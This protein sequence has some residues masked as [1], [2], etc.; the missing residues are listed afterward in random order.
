[1][2][3]VTVLDQLEI[4]LL[5]EEQ[6]WDEEVDG[7]LF[8]LSDAEFEGEVEYDPYKHRKARGAHYPSGWV[9]G[10]GAV[11][12]LVEAARLLVEATELRGHLNEQLTHVH[13]TALRAKRC[14]VVAPSSE[15]NLRAVE[16]TW[17]KGVASFNASKVLVEAGFPVDTGYRKRYKVHL[18]Q[19]SKKGPVLIIDMRQPV[20][21]K[22]L[23]KRKRKAR[24]GAQ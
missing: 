13:V 14:L 21:V 4:G 9:Q 3:K 17:K 11:E 18:L 24:K 10:P 15:Q 16:V 1:M 23:P 20:A 7:E 5:G 6:P 12:L 8:A 19:T 2:A 22:V